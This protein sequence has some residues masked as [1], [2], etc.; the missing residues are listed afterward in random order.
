[1]AQPHTDVDLRQ[2]GVDEKIQSDRDARASGSSGAGFSLSP[3]E[4][5][6]ILAQADEV[7]DRLEQLKRDTGRLKQVAPAAGDPAS[8]AYNSRLASGQG[9]FD[10]AS[11]HV[12]AEVDYLGEL[13]TKIKA[14]LRVLGG[15]EAEAARD[16]GKAG[17]PS[18]GLA[19]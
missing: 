4:A 19:G 11:Q 9:V 6:A 16:I 1:M 18:G 13:I 2:A 3:A 5:Q 17:V 10:A 14:G 15:H 8:V 7:L 12:K